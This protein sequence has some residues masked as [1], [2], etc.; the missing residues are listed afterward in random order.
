M[1]F[2]GKSQNPSIAAEIINRALDFTW[3]VA[4][5]SNPSRK[6]MK[7]IRWEKPQMGWYKLNTDGA[8]GLGVDRTGCGG[9]IRD[10]HGQ[11]ITGF[12]RR[13]GAANSL[14]AELWGLRDGLQLCCSRNFDSIE[15]EIDAKGVLDAFL[16]TDHANS[17]VS[18]ILDDCR[19][20]I[21]RFHRIS[22]KHCYR[23]V[24][25]CADKLARLGANQSLEFIIF[26]SP[27][28]DILSSLEED[29]VGMYFSR[30]CP[31]TSGF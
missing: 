13:I 21:S 29:A 25:R 31:V 5:I 8:A 9:I 24:N 12:A 10:E 15:V 18:P 4:S 2:N 30:L 23:E 1:V 7:Q 11:W 20:L 17:I 26:Q 28:V 14:T 6:V 27:S 3:C 16:N 19:M 22:L